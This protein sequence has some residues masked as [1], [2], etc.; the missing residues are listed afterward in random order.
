M[1]GI[2]SD[3]D[4]IDRIQAVG[5]MRKVHTIVAGVDFKT[6]REINFKMGELSII[7]LHINGR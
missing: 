4:F 7:T 1:I 6:E 5:T 2:A 3:V